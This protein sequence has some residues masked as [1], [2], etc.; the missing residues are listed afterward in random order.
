[1]I[2]TFDHWMERLN[3]CCQLDFGIS[4]HD[5]PD[6]LF[7]DAYDSGLSPEDF[8]SENLPDEEALGHV[9]LS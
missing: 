1:M 3:R 2:L 7:R 4:I 6:M 8:M 5:L 9:I